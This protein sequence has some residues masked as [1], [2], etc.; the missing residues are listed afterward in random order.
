[1]LVMMEV[2]SGCTTMFG[3]GLTSLPWAITIFSTG[4]TQAQMMKHTNAS[5]IVCS[6]R[7]T[8][9]GSGPRSM[10]SASGRNSISVSSFLPRLKFKGDLFAGSISAG[11]FRYG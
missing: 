2:S 3:S 1:M 8:N 11:K 7:R 9:F 10:A 6:V 5:S 4:D